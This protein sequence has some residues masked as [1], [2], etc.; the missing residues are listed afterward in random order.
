M[1]F[2]GV[3]LKG[4]LDLMEKQL[5][6]SSVPHEAETFRDQVRP[7]LDGSIIVRSTRFIFGK[8]LYVD[9]HF[10]THGEQKV[11]SIGW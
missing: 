6:G 9:D 2:L 5:G 7:I 3:I 8:L 10:T 1:S 11:G 4:R